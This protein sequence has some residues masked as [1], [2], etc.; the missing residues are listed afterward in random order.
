MRLFTSAAFGVSLLALASTPTMAATPSIPLK[1]NADQPGAVIDRH[2]FGQFAEHLGHGVYGG[3]WVGKDSSI[4]NTRGIRNDVVAAL[5]AIKVPDVRW[6]GGCYAD[7]YHWRDGVGA[8]RKTRVNTAWGNVVDP[9]TFGTDEYMDFI[10]QIGSEAYVSL[11]IGS[12]TVGEAQDWMEYMTAD[13]PTTLQQAR[14]QNGHSAPYNVPFMGVGNESWDC[15]GL[16][17]PDEY[18]AELR[19]YARFVG[20][21][22]PK[23]PTMKIAVGP[24]TD[25]TV[26]TDAVMKTWKE[27][28]GWSF[29]FQG[30]SLHSYTVYDGWPPHMPSTGFDQAAYAHVLKETL[31][32]GPLIDKQTAVM[33]KY[34]PDKKVALVVDEWGAWLA[35]T[36]GSN[37]AFLMQQNTQR[38]AVLAALNLNIFA[39]HADRVR[40]ANIAQMVNV[41]QAM[42]LTDGPKMV[43]TPTYYV[44]KLYVPFQDATFIP[45]AYDAGTYTQGDATLPRLDAIAARGKDGKIWLSLTNLDPNQPLEVDAAALG[46]KASAAS[47]QTLSAPKVDSLNDFDHPD[48]V[49]PRPI[50]GK[51][52][53][54]A[55]VLTLPPAS[56]TVVSLEP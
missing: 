3:I 36:P 33:D 6:P 41:L 20:S 22:N 28:R 31:K 46:F 53:N 13:Q 45:V 52:R 54:G 5:K 7:S 40:M 48:A 9:N 29:D 37:P 38:D 14:A 43:L 19:R 39:R 44:F 24:G 27:R 55:I 11:N 42:I 47:G 32:M 4:P 15:G 23:Q 35:P 17:T 18:T 16:M 2:I 25:D 12:G 30:L 56:V 51:L 26:W 49:T 21:Y 50:S 1:I 34:D 8:D 10:N